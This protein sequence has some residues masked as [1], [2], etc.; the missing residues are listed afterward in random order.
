MLELQGWDSVSPPS[1]QVKPPCNGAGL[2]HVL[3]RVELP[4]L[5]VELQADHTPH[6]AHA[7]FTDKISTPDITK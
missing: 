5:Q 2:V 7:P 1:G 6:T 3:V 4:P